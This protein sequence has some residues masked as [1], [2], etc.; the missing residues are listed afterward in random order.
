MCDQPSQQSYSIAIN[1]VM[2]ICGKEEPKHPKR[3]KCVGQL[4]ADGIFGDEVVIM[5]EEKIEIRSI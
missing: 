4:F 1:E 5:T 3:L 2:D